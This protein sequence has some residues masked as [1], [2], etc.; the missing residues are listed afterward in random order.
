[1]AARLPGVTVAD[2]ERLVLGAGAA[3]PAPRR[4]RSAT[5]R[6]LAA[7]LPRLVGLGA[8]L[9]GRIARAEEHV[10]VLHARTAAAEG[11][12]ADLAAVL[13]D[14][15]DLGREVATTHVAVSGASAVR[16][17]APRAPPR[18]AGCPAKPWRA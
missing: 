15:L 12:Q 4:A 2:A 17:G 1:M 10:R 3:A 9:P 11:G 8:G 13:G 7:M 16:L 5:S 18:R 6:R 14:F